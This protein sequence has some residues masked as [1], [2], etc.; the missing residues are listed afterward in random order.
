[1]EGGENGNQLLKVGVNRAK[2]SAEKIVHNAKRKEK[3]TIFQA[4][5]PLKSAFAL[6]SSVVPAHL[7]EKKAKMV[8]YVNFRYPSL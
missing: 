4:C 6:L 8:F 2:F 5:L 7:V 3:V 1:M